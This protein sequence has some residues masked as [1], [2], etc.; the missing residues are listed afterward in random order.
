MGPWH[1]PGVSAEEL[2]LPWNP[3]SPN[4]LPE[5]DEKEYGA[6]F[7]EGA[8][9]D[10]QKSN[11]AGEPSAA[12]PSSDSRRGGIIKNKA[13]P[14]SGRVTLNKKSTTVAPEHGFGDQFSLPV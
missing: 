14:S 11:R 5:P 10:F 2:P 9:P 3:S 1:S 6:S 12:K 4:I 8:N 13:L 7:D